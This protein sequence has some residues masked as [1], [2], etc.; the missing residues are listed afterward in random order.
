MARALGGQVWDSNKLHRCV[1]EEGYHGFDCGQRKCPR[2]DDPLTTDQVNE[3][4][5]VV[6]EASVL[7][8]PRARS[9]NDSR[10]SIDSA[11]EHE[12]GI[13][14]SLSVIICFKCSAKP[15]RKGTKSTHRGSCL[16]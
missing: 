16:G 8:K 9:G 2:G 3:V 13:A 11:Q 14:L 12:I 15:L 6:C 10:L 7:T 1:C 5:L 4:Q